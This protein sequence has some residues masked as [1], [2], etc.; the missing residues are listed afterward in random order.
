MIEYHRIRRIGSITTT[1]KIGHPAVI[2]QN[3]I[4]LTVG[5]NFEQFKT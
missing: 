5:G 2:P 1:D 4:S 3:L